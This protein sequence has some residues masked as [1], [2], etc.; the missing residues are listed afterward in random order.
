M[1][2][3]SGFFPLKFRIHWMNL[4]RVQ[5]SQPPSSDLRIPASK[6]TVEKVLTPSDHQ[7]SELYPK[8][9]S[10]KVK[11]ELHSIP[12]WEVP[13]YTWCQNSGAPQETASLKE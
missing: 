13:V 9:H 6:D 2:L 5:K 4:I 12:F 3:H 8:R 7:Q 1:G 10:C 11:I